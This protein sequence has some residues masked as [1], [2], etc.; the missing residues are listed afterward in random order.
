MSNII[1]LIIHKTKSP[2]VGGGDKKT[3]KNTKSKIQKNYKI[4]K[5][6]ILFLEK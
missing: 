1:Y 4:M 5:K 6:T 3:Q 2:G